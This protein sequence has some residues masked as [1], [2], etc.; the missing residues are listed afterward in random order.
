[1][2]PVWKAGHEKEYFTDLDYWSFFHPHSLFQGEK[3]MQ[4]VGKDSSKFTLVLVAWK[5]GR[6][7]HTALA[8][9][10]G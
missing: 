1:M 8:N 3:N 9:D 10:A 2:G 6:R 5:S 4:V 7:S